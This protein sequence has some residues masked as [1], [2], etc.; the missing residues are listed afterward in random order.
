MSRAERHPMITASGKLAQAQAW[1]HAK[2]MATSRG[3]EVY[4]VPVVTVSG[5][6]EVRDERPLHIP[7]IT[8]SPALQQQCT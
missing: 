6:W 1:R 8:V 2:A 4:I 7:A 3:R 5:L